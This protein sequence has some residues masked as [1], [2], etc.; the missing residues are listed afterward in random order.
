MRALTLLCLLGLSL[1][2]S[3]QRFVRFISTDGKEYTGDAILKPNDFDAAHSTQ[4]KVIT[5]DILG[6]FRI[7]NE[8]KKIKTLLAPISPERIRTVRCVGFNYANHAEEANMTLPGWPVLFYKPW[9]ALSTPSAPIL[10]TSGYQNQT[11]FTSQMDYETE[12]VVVI[13]KKAF[14]ISEDEALD[15]VLGYASGNDVSHRGWQIAR[16]GL[17][18]PQVSMGKGADTWAP[19]GPALVSTS[20]IP[21]PQNLTLWTKVNGVLKQNDTTANMLFG[22]KHLVSFFSM[23]ITLLPGDIIFT[24]TPSGVNLGKANPQWLTKGDVVEVGVSNIG[25]NTNQITYP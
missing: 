1:T 11:N 6:K 25:T 17:P 18:Q 19:W 10:V 7:T 15:H 23:G 8:V 20:L 21:D 2:A 22:V 9:T 14:N 5:G 16:G 3:A 13:K 4:A 24:G 12:L